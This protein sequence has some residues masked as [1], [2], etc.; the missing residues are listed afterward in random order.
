MPL[1]SS[2]LNHWAGKNLWAQSAFDELSVKLSDSA[3][4]P[5]VAASHTA[6]HDCH[7]A[8]GEPSEL[9]CLLLCFLMR[10]LAKILTACARK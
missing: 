8:K 7:D 2:D 10:L 1:E 3:A 9:L 6:L 4:V 5:N